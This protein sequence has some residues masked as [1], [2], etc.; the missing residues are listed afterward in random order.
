MSA[1]SEITL[2]GRIFIHVFPREN[3][4]TSRCRKNTPNTT[5]NS[6]NGSRSIRE[7]NEGLSVSSVLFTVSSTVIAI[8]SEVLSP[9]EFLRGDLSPPMFQL[10]SFYGV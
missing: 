3:T 6:P 7:S 1:A 2:Q 9:V 4:K 8:T 10:F 5:M